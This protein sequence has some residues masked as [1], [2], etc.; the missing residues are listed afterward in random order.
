[1]LKLSA[2]GTL[3]NFW[4]N[5]ATRDPVSEEEAKALLQLQDALIKEFEKT[6]TWYL[7]FPSMK[8]FMEYVTK[9]KVWAK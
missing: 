7:D 6:L 4:I 1:M 5:L 3:A 2:Y 8:A 9:H